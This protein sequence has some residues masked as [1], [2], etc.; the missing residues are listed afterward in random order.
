VFTI[1]GAGGAGVLCKSIIY[2]GDPL[3]GKPLTKIF[4]GADKD[5]NTIGTKSEAFSYSFRS[6]RTYWIGVRHSASTTVVANWSASA[7]ADIF[8]AGYTSGGRKSLRRT[9]T[10]ATAAPSTWTWSASEL[11]TI[12]PWAFWIQAA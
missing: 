5:A 7:G 11:T 3:T 4:E 10:Y 6:D 1:N 2:E 8:L 12:S 9:L